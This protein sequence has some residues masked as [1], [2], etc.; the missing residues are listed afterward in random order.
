MF[1]ANA[2]LPTTLTAAFY[3]NGAELVDDSR[4]QTSSALV[5]DKTVL[6][7][8]TVLSLSAADTIAVWAA[9]E[10]NDGYIAAAQ[11]GFYGHRIG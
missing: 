6:S 1:K 11:N 5:S 7:C 9:M 2:A 3:K 8:N 4:V 10:T